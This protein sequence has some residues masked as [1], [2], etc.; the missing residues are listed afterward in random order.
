MAIVTGRYWERFVTGEGPSYDRGM[1]V[2]YGVLVAVGAAA[3]AVTYFVVEHEY[4][5]ADLAYSAGVGVFLLTL[6][7]L[8]SFIFLR[9]GYK[10]LSFCGV[11]AACV[12]LLASLSVRVLPVIGS[13]ESSRVLSEMV[14]ELSSPDDLVGGE[15]DHRRGVAFYTGRIDITDVHP[16]HSLKDFMS[17]GD[18]VWCIIQE[19]HYRQLK[20]ETPD[21]VTDP[22]SRFGKSVLITNKKIVGK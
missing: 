16:Y 15:D 4:P 3:T 7:L 19:K 22:L 21:V 2:A 9:R 1:R 14:N 10:R 12:L 11:V 17:R 20:E 6:V 13:Y 18:T 5:D 8:V